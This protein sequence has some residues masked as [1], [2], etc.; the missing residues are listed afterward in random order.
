MFHHTNLGYPLTFKLNACN[1]SGRFENVL[2]RKLLTISDD[3]A[4][5][6][7]RPTWFDEMINEWTNV[8]IDVCCRTGIIYCRDI[9]LAMLTPPP[10]TD[11]WPY[12]K[13][14]LKRDMFIWVLSY[15]SFYSSA[16]CF[17]P[18]SFICD[19]TASVFLLSMITLCFT[20]NST[21]ISFSAYDKFDERRV[22]N[23]SRRAMFTTAAAGL[24][25]WLRSANHIAPKSA[26]S[27]NC[28]SR[29][30]R[31]KIRRKT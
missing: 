13:V 30:W 29:N 1:S 8:Q 16:S 23:F 11:H 22:A 4:V 14:I 10:P 31:I 5:N 9:A 25:D 2:Q 28:R 24:I 15:V 7:C 20:S 17:H 6:L 3:E 26:E 19:D 12:D 27:T 18:S 21:S